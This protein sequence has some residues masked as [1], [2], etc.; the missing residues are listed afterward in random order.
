MSILAFMGVNAAAF[1]RYFLRAREK[2]W[3]NLVSPLLGFAICFYI[4]QSLGPHAK[5]LGGM[6][7]IIGIAYGAV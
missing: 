1:V 5:L 4:W 2:H 3:T 6:W 7:T